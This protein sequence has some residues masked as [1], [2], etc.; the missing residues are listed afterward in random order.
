MEFL[1]L[2]CT[3]REVLEEQLLQYAYSA[4]SDHPF[5][6]TWSLFRYILSK[7]LLMYSFAEQSFVLLDYFIMHCQKQCQW[8]IYAGFSPCHWL[9]FWKCYLISW[10]GNP[11]RV[12][13]KADSVSSGNRAQMSRNLQAFRSWPDM[14]WEIRFPGRRRSPGSVLSGPVFSVSVTV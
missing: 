7:A 11:L 8:G 10:S 6:S 14:H 4:L 3:V 5:R 12:D 1:T 2:F 9:W 13:R